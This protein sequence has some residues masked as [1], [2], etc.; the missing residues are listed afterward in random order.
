MKRIYECTTCGYLYDEGCGDPDADIDAGTEFEDLPRTWT[1][2]ICS[3]PK[4][5]FEQIDT[6]NEYGS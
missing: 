6:D 5:E 3:A 4:S 2:P 1:C